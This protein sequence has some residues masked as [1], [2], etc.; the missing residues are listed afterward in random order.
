MKIE[1]VRVDHTSWGEDVHVLVVLDADNGLAGVGEAAN[2]TSSQILR[3]AAEEVV[4]ELLGR[5]PFESNRLLDD[6]AELKDSELLPAVRNGIET[7]CVDLVG[8]QLGVSACQ[9]FGGAVRNQIRVCA[10]DWRNGSASLDDWAKSAAHV[11]RAGF[12]ALAL[13]PFLRDRAYNRWPESK[14]AV[15]VVRRVRE[16][17]GGDVD[18]VVDARNRFTASEA[19]A[20]AEELSPLSIFYLQDPVPCGDLDALEQL[21]HAVPIPIAVGRCG[22]NGT[23]LRQI[24]E[25]QLADFIHLDSASLGGIS[26]ARAFGLLAESWFMSV[27]LCHAGGLPAMATNMQMATAIPNCQMMDLPFSVI[28]SWQEVFGTPFKLEDGCIKLPAGTG[29]AL[30]CEVLMRVSAASG[31]A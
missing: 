20:I 5:D 25:R 10:T 26:R 7:A 13:D 24:I 6:L 12:T 16:T 29:L 21:R 15:D 31:T 17:V 18:L 4:P 30:D 11:A 3:A 1:K 14:Q 27:T 22:A 2:V 28:D 23:G 9:L 19:I 8:K